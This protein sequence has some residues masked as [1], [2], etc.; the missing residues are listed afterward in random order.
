MA[1]LSELRKEQWDEI[2]R[3]SICRATLELLN[4]RGLGELTMERVAKAADVSTGTLYN[5]VRDKDEL[6][7]HVIDT[8]F[9]PIR[10]ALEEIADGALSPPDKLRA[11]M[12]AVFNG[13]EDN[14]AL[15]A[16]MHKATASALEAQRRKASIRETLLNLVISIVDEGLGKGHF[17]QCDRVLAGRLILA[18]IDGYLLSALDGEDRVNVGEKEALACADLLFNGLC[19]SDRADTRKGSDTVNT[20]GRGK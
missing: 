5:Y 4:S 7:A 9:E 8:T 20:S 13:F 16:I 14:R 11:L 2:M 18:V 3:K 1:R 10:E 12:V 17:R 15:I 6:L 19:A